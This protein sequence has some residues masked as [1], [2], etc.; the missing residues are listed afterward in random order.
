MSTSARGLRVLAAGLRLR[1]RLRDR[2]ALPM[3]VAGILRLVTPVN[4]GDSVMMSRL[5]VEARTSDPQSPR[6]HVDRPT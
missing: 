6:A 4:D 1:L 3:A 2:P 5:G